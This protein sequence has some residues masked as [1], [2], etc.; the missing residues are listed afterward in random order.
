MDAERLR[1]KLDAGRGE[2]V[3]ALRSLADQLEALD[4]TDVGE[5]LAWI[6]PHLRRLREEA[7]RVLEQKGPTE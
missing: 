1:A 2:A 4:L 6:E 5:S 7:E 3:R